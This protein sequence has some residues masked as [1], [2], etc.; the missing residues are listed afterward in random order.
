MTFTITLSN[1]VD[2]ETSVTFSTSNGSATTGDSDYSAVTTQTVVFAAGETSKTVTVNTTS[3]SKVEANETFSATLSGLNDGGRSV[4][5]ATATA[6]G[7]I[8]NDDPSPNVTLSVSSATIAEALGTATITA[9]LS[10]VSDFE[11]TVELGFGGVGTTAIDYT[12]NTALIV[13][14]AGNTSGTATLT[15]I[16]DSLS[17]SDESIVVDIVSVTNGVESGTQQVT[18]TI[19]DDDRTDVSISVSPSGVQ[20]DGTA[21]L[22]Y[23]LTRTGF[24]TGALTVAFTVSGS[25]T[26]T[27]DYAQSGAATFSATNGTISFAAGQLSK[28]ITVNP[29]AD[30]V[31]ESD[32]SLTLTITPSASY[33]LVNGASS[34]TGTIINDDF[35]RITLAASPTSLLENGGTNAAFTFTRTGPTTN[36]LTVNFSAG[37]TATLN[38]DYS[39]TGASAFTESSG[40]VTFAAGQ[41]TAVVTIDPTADSTLEPNETVLLVM[42]AGSDYVV[43]TTSVVTSIILN[44]DQEVSVRVSPGSITEDGT[45]N[46]VYTFTRTGATSAALTANFTVGGTATFT[47]DYSQ[48]GASTFTASS[49]TVAFT[50]GQLS[51]VVTINPTADTTIESDELVSLRLNVSTNYTIGAAGTATGIIVND[52]PRITL[53]IAPATIVENGSTN[54]VY[55]FTRTGS[56]SSPLTVHFHVGGTATFGA[57]YSVLGAA[58]F[59]ESDGTVTFAVGQATKT[60]TIDPTGD[61][62]FE[63]NET[64]SLTVSPEPNYVVGT[65][66]AIT[67]TITN[68]DTE[69]NVSV[70]PTNGVTENGSPN[71]IY[72]FTRRGPANSALS[73][74]FTIGG[75]ATFAT[76]YSQTGADSFNATSGL[77]TVTIAAG[78]TTKQVTINPTGDTLPELDETVV[79]TVT[80]KPAYS[81]GTSNSATGTIINDDGPA[82]LRSSS[83]VTQQSPTTASLIVMPDTSKKSLFDVF[84]RN[85]GDL[86]NAMP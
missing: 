86:M 68:D 76:D 60:V 2:A 17:E 10:A 84:S 38:S 64:V 28:T 3:D 19:R 43:G 45:A 70:S 75:T 4:T 20:E 41:S 66:S 85:V 69:V 32:E 22:T 9:T 52:D 50:A 79:L 30:T 53:A 35:P 44:D 25:V 71:L 46:L 1:A 56:T 34:A 31:I 40:S 73:V 67:S 18:T 21:N 23:T 37:G 63:S 15:A 61:T 27:T 77:G 57:D 81:V 33:S 6:T 36:P 47:S 8:N 65:T 5:I 42:A 12:H 83:P 62:A 72:T 55:T 51:K 74:N 24:A 26:L 80:S 14:N 48:T 49:G 16:Q 82:S 59:S 7:T 13:V 58:S 11:V 78:Q 39:T 54:S 29:V